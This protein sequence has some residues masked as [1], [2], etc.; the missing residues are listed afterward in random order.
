M[1][2]NYAKHHRMWVER[3]E[4]DENITAYHVS[5]YQALFQY[6]NENQFENPVGVN[7]KDLMKRAKIGSKNTYARHIKQLHEW[8]YIVYKPVYGLYELSKVDMVRFDVRGEQNSVDQPAKK[9]T[10]T[11]A[12]VPKVASKRIPKYVPEVLFFFTRN[13]SDTK[14]AYRFIEYY[15]TN[16][17]K[18]GPR[19]MKDWQAVALKWITKWKKLRNKRKLKQHRQTL[20]LKQ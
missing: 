2:I 10:A 8:G 7:R 19:R 12:R 13:G 3:C 20:K 16:G 6:W 5:L 9:N 1:K 11:E 14:E 18:D 15:G 4:N 17:W